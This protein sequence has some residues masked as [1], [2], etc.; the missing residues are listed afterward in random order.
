MSFLGSLTY[1][2]LGVYQEI[3]QDKQRRQQQNQSD[4]DSLL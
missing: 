2:T 3:L 1:M 4:I